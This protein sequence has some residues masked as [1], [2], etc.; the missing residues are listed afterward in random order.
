MP[1]FLTATAPELAAAARSMSD[2][3]QETFIAEQY[4]CSHLLA[5]DFFVEKLG[6]EHG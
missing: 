6:C 5:S 3:L 2:S 1:I 4:G